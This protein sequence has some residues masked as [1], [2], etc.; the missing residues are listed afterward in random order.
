[1]KFSRIYQLNFMKV[2]VSAIFNEFFY[3]NFNEVSSSFLGLLIG[4]LALLYGYQLELF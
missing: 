2:P 4:V 3:W 1:M